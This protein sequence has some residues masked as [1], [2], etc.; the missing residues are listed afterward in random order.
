ME[1]VGE[2]LP[3]RHSIIIIT[4]HDISM[5]FVDLHRNRTIRSQRRGGKSRSTVIVGLSKKMIA[6]SEHTIL[7]NNQTREKQTQSK[8]YPRCNPTTNLCDTKK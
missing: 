3:E 1:K 2:G 4:I 7:L 5:H 8:T 6:T